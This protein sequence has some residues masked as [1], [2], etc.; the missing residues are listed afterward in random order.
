MMVG[1]PHRPPVSNQPQENASALVA[2]LDI[3]QEHPWLLFRGV[4]GKWPEA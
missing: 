2:T 1:S 4:H 3:V